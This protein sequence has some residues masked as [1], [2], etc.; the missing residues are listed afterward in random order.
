LF[1]AQHVSARR[2]HPQGVIKIKAYKPT[3]QYIFPAPRCNN[4]QE[5][6]MLKYINLIAAINN[7]IV[8]LNIKKY[9]TKTAIFTS[10]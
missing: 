9:N 3:D 10:Y 1:K 2:C 6:K 4:D 7:S 8:I 5:L